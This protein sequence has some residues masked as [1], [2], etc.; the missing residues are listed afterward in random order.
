MDAEWTYN[1]LKQHCGNGPVYV[2][3]DTIRVSSDSEEDVYDFPGLLE[4]QPNIKLS[5]KNIMHSSGEGSSKDYLKFIVNYVIWLKIVVNVG[6]ECVKS[7]FR[8]CRFQTFPGENLPD[9]PLIV[10]HMA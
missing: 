1:V 3:P 9:T 5:R 4:E 8:G 2:C 10:A 6:S 7:R